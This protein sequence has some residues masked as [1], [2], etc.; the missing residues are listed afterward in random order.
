M[1]NIKFKQ[2]PQFLKAEY[3]RMKKNAAMG[4]YEAA[5]LEEMGRLLKSIEGLKSP[6]KEQA[7]LQGVIQLNHMPR[8][9][10]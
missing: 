2:Y 8:I 7:F 3:H 1:N 10:A 6:Q 9:A 5:N 4:S